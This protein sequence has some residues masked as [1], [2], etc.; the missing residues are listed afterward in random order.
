MNN[1]QIQ[2]GG[3]PYE[4]VSPY[5]EADLNDI[6]Y[7]QSADV[8][9]LF[10]PKYAPRKL[11]RTGHTA[12]TLTPIDFST[13][14]NRPALMPDNVTTTTITPSADTGSGITLT[15]SAALF[16]TSSPS[17]HIGSIWK[18]KS[19]YVKITAV[20]DSTHAT[21]DVLYGISLGTGPGATAEWAEGAWSEYRGYPS[22]GT[23]YEQRLM[24]A[25][26]TSQPQTVWGSC[27]LEYENFE[28]GADDADALD[29]TIATEQVEAIKWLFPGKELFLGTAGGG[30][31]FKLWQQRNTPDSFKTS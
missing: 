14:T 9:Y 1:G 2:S 10:H 15:A 16:D 11:S 6:Q 22:C 20:T 12:W 3:S 30:H 29:Y 27:V 13:G 8:M 28:R 17:K 19:G 21:G 5:A 23:F 18:V 31:S 7:A 4:I 26:T 25:A 24:A